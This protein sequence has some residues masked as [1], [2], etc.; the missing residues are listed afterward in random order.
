MCKINAYFQC[1]QSNLLC[2]SGTSKRALEI[3]QEAQDF[4]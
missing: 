2:D 4:F 1:N 3:N